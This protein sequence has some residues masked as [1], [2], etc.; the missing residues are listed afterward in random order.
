[1]SPIRALYLLFVG[2]AICFMQDKPASYRER[3]IHYGESSRVAAST[4]TSNP[5]TTAGFTMREA[6]N[7]D[8]SIVISFL[9]QLRK[10]HDSL[11][12]G[13]TIR[14]TASLV[15]GGDTIQ[16]LMPHI[17]D[18]HVVL[19]QPTI[20]G[21]IERICSEPIGFASYHLRY[22]GFGPPLLHMEHL[23]VNP[24]CRSQGAGLALMNELANIGKQYRCSHME[25]SVSKENVRGV[26]FYH[27]IGAVTHVIKDPQQEVVMDLVN[28]PNN[29]S[30][31]HDE[32][33][34]TMKW[35]PAAWDLL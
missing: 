19:A 16:S 18:C 23:F 3:H 11:H 15:K 12:D 26:Q 1:M 2:P 21:D 24:N 8:T 5:G 4:R 9:D 34:N 14:A 7:H 35:I 13:E 30:S 22:T 25:W 20:E 17:R 32:A 33:S 28:S 6:Q 10:F 27:R 31:S 29:L